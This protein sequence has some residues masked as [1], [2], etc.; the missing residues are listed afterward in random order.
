MGLRI[1][2]LIIVIGRF[3]FYTTQGLS[4]HLVVEVKRRKN[5]LEEWVSKA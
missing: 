5:L 2:A 4:K 3:A 1:V